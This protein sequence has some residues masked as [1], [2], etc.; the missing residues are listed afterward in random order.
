MALSPPR[1]LFLEHP[2]IHSFLIHSLIPHPP[3]PRPRH[4][5]S[6]NGV[7]ACLSAG[8]SAP[9]VAPAADALNLLLLDAS[10]ASFHPG[11]AEEDDRGG[12]SA[13]EYRLI[14]AGPRAVV[15]PRFKVAPTPPG[16]LDD[17]DPP[18]GCGAGPVVPGRGID[19][20]AKYPAAAPEP[21]PP[22]PPCPCPPCLPSPPAPAAA[23][24][25]AAAAD[26]GVG[27]ASA[28]ARTS[29]RAVELCL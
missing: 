7:S 14:V 21:L 23:A 6:S 10:Y 2:C 1:A 13:S 18:A 11:T 25:S 20:R 29:M 9:A 16:R 15:S 4:R 3:L 24:F 8:E 12:P 27:A 28:R 5:S 19:A 22:R 17:D 26:E